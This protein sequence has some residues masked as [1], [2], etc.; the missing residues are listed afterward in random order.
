MLRYSLSITYT[1][2][3]KIKVK[4]EYLLIQNCDNAV[5][6][7]EGQATFNHVTFL[8]N[9]VSLWA[10]HSFIAINNSYFSNC[11]TAI[12]L[13]DSVLNISSTQINDNFCYE[14]CKP[15]FK[16]NANCGAGLYVEIG[17]HVVA[18]NCWNF[19]RQQMLISIIATSPI[20]LQIEEYYLS[21]M[22]P[23]LPLPTLSSLSIM[24]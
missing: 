9:N 13:R 12:Y 4:F 1:H 2:I 19:F 8:H 3:F 15:F 21:M 20:I 22:P 6:V 24:L 23:Q 14:D 7:D 16:D 18:N 5:K 11:M 10:D 17:S